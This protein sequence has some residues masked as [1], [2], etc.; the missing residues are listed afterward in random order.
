MRFLTVLVSVAALFAFNASTVGVS[1]VLLD[2]DLGHIL[3]LDFT[4][5]THYNAP[6]EPWR[7]GASPGWYI[8]QHPERHP[9]LFCLVG[10]ICKILD[11]FPGLPKCPKKPVPPKPTPTPTGTAP[12]PTPTLPA[13]GY[14]QTFTNLTGATQ[15]EGYLTFGLVDTIPD[16]KAFCDTVKG[17]IFA[18]TYND[19]NGKDGSTQLTCS[20][21]SRCHDA[22]TATNTGGQ[23]QPDG[24]VNYIRNS[25]GWCKK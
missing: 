4:E 10:I 7:N 14:E 19:V 12:Y 1:A 23:T 16:C 24:S 22:S 21:F 3:G 18:N 8:G 5:R 9:K 13:D 6:I 25:N 11:L 15:G 2:L 20:L 17:C